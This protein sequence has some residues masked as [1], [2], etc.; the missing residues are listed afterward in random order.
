VTDVFG[1][2]GYLLYR[3]DTSAAAASLALNFGGNGQLI[4]G[5]EAIA[6]GP[7]SESPTPEPPTILAGVWSSQYV[8][9]R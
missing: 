9:N 7:Q 6:F 2:T 3:L 8:E 1:G 5:I 4:P